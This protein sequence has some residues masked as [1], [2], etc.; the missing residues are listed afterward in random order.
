MIDCPF[1]PGDRIRNPNNH[2]ETATV[3]DL[4]ERGFAYHLDYWQGVPRLGM[5]WQDGECYENGFHLWERVPDFPMTTD[6]PTP[7]TE[8]KMTAEGES[9]LI[10]GPPT[11][12]MTL[13]ASHV[14][15]IFGKDGEK[16][17]TIEQDGTVVVSNEGADREA[18]KRFY[19]ALQFYGQTLFG[20][21]KEL[22]ARLAKHETVE[23]LSLT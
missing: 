23:P 7:L 11:P 12:I 6:T 2:A 20:R 8:G 5:V 22:E 18:A 15:A 4:T 14:I 19:E 3:T 1:A 13:T 21:V 16:L 10:S 9:R 17:V